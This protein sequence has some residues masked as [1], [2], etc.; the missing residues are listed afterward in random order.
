[1][2][3]SADELMAMQAPN[4]MFGTQGR[5]GIFVPRTGLAA[6]TAGSAIDGKQQPATTGTARKAPT[7]LQDR[8]S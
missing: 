8:R 1:V 2:P 5:P 6:G 7:S 3:R 4:R